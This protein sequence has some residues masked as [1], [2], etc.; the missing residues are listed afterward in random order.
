MFISTNITNEH[1][2]LDGSRL[3]RV[4]V[5]TL[6]NDDFCMFIYI[7]W[8]L[9]WHANEKFYLLVGK[10]LQNQVLTKK[11]INIKPCQN[12]AASLAISAS[13]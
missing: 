6:Y 11:I 10:R 7:N 8:V 3:K 13:F 9:F 5:W 12:T 4:V 1:F 2:L